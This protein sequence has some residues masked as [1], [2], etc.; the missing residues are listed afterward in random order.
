MV[1]YL[2]VGGGIAGLY[3]AYK[4]SI[5]FNTND[6]IIIE[7]EKRFGGRIFTL[8]ISNDT[9]IEL[10][11][12]ILNS[13][14][15]NTIKLVKELGLNDKLHFVVPK[16]SYL[17]FNKIINIKA[18]DGDF[19]KNLEFLKDYKKN[20]KVNHFSLYELIENTL[21]KDTADTTTSMHG[22]DGDITLQNADDGIEML[23]RDYTH[24]IG[25]LKGGLSQIVNNLMEILISRGILLYNNIELTGIE[26][27]NNMYKSQI[28]YNNNKSRTSKGIASE[29]VI[30]AIPK[31]ALL[32]IQ[33]LYSSPYVTSLLSSVS[34]KQLIRIYLKFEVINNMVWFDIINNTITTPTILRQIIPINKE[35]GIIMIYVS[36]NN[37]ILLNYLHKQNLLEDV[38]I[39]NL[40]KLFGIYIPKPL[41]M[42]VKFWKEATHIWKPN[43]DSIVTSQR[44]LQPFKND[45]VYIIGETYAPKYQQWIEGALITANN[46]IKLFL[47]KK[48]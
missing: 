47:D 3:M 28:L 10:G 30:L 9:N 44:I 36:D 20:N 38:I 48:L 21:G 8:P 39:D 45:N 42:Y 2:I 4:L 14:S 37:A 6:I 43:V 33:Y 25:F 23:S 29:N 41:K 40:R 32:K 26:K 11:A 13:N 19:M 27:I 31:I 35:K 7:K 24:E 16:K 5:K 46:L 12:G 22:Y 1:K 15:I 34:S 18:K 17:K